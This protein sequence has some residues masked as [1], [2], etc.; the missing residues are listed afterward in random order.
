MSRTNVGRRGWHCESADLGADLRD[1][2]LRGCDLGMAVLTGAKLAGA[3]LAK[4]RFD[5]WR[6]WT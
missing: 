4:A 6:I 5:R 3:D 1:A 2:T